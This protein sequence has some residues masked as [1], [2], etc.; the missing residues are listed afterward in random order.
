MA[1][2]D[3]RFGSRPVPESGDGADDERG[4]WTP[5]DRGWNLVLDFQRLD[6][7][8]MDEIVARHA[9]HP[10]A[11]RL[12]DEQGACIHRNIYQAKDLRLFRENWRRLSG[13]P[14]VQ[15]YLNGWPASGE[16]I[17]S[18]L[19]CHIEHVLDQG[20]DA[21]RCAVGGE[22]PDHL[23]CHDY[24]IRLRYRPGPPESARPHW[25]E[26]SRPLSPETWMLDTHRIQAFLNRL[27]DRM[28]CPALSFQQINA[29]LKQ[30]PERID[31][32]ETGIWKYDY[33]PLAVP[34]EKRLIPRDADR[35]HAYMEQL[36]RNSGVWDQPRRL[37]MRRGD[38]AE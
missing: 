31:V 21:D 4:E 2:E 26:L 32:A 17:E 20:H 7:P 1:S 22:F 5:V 37:Q 13:W 30:L 11:V 12:L 27:R 6:R 33:T 36:F 24:H 10:G 35:Y 18:F 34:F 23:G 25:F 14:G 3:P 8:D 28:A 38:G 16:E 15:A 19:D 29:C 9:L